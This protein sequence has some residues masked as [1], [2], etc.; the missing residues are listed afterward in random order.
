METWVHS[1]MDWSWPKPP[2]AFPLS[3]VVSRE[4]HRAVSILSCSCQSPL[5]AAAEARA[6]SLVQLFGIIGSVVIRSVLRLHACEACGV[7]AA[8]V[9]MSPS[10]KPSIPSQAATAADVTS[11]SLSV[12][13]ALAGFES[14]AAPSHIHAVDCCVQQVAAAPATIPSNSAGKRCASIKASCPPSE[15]AAQRG[16]QRPAV[17]SVAGLQVLSVPRRRQQDFHVDPA[18]VPRLP[19]PQHLA[20]RRNCAGRGDVHGGGDAHAVKSNQLNSVSA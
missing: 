10:T 13:R 6:A 12:E 16:R 20:T 5:G 14:A 3:A 11:F 19:D 1:N 4:A 7:V 18:V 2:L 15:H 17:T 8:A 9:A